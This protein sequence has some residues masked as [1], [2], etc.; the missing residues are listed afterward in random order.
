MRWEDE[1]F[2]K[3]YT[4]PSVE[5]L[6]LPLAAR[7]LFDELM[8]VVDAHGILS[9]GKLGLG[10]VATAVRATWEEVD[11]PLR[12]LLE[13]G[14]VQWDERHGV[15]CLPNFFEAQN[16]RQTD[17][18]RKRRSRSSVDGPTDRPSRPSTPAMPVPAPSAVRP[19]TRGHTESRDVTPSHTASENVTSLN[20]I[21]EEGINTPLSPHGG[22]PGSGVHPIPPSEQ[23]LNGMLWE[24]AYA[25]AVA[26]ENGQPWTFP[27]QTRRTLKRVLDAHCTGQNRRDI[28]KWIDRAAR[29]FV[30]AT[31]ANASVWSGF[32]PDGLERW[33]N[34]GKPK[35]T[36]RPPRDTE[37]RPSEHPQSNIL[38]P[39]KPIPRVAS[40]AGDG[41]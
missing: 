34:S 18:A 14:C 26:E 7:G 33:L 13:D 23:S 8:K 19:V 40:G 35:T 30:R 24:Q 29:E 5:F 1:P 21:G 32:S 31:K 16:A 4:H 17:R 6:A 12:I 2:V 10:G 25:S 22:E 37:P 38:K 3:L 41:S 11:G 9:V 20:G 39:M 28:P 15:V 27:P 36:L